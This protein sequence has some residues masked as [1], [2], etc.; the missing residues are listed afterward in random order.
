MLNV[1]TGKFSSIC[2]KT[3]VVSQG[4]FHS[5]HVT[6]IFTACLNTG[7][8]W[9]GELQS[10]WRR[11]FKG[12]VCRWL[13]VLYLNPNKD[14]VLSQNFG[15]SIQTIAWSRSCQIMFLSTIEKLMGAGTTVAQI[16]VCQKLEV[17][18]SKLSFMISLKYIW[19][20]IKL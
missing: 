11:H 8:S 19:K 18:I 9:E 13:S 14:F 7:C 16:F 6:S 10:H 4:N 17:V 20:Y 1:G 2:S 15:F 12:A 3:Y 5:C